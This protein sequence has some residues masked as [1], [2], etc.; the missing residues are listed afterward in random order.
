[1][2]ECYLICKQKCRTYWLTWSFQVK[3]FQTVH[4]KSAEKIKYF[5]R[6]VFVYGCQKANLSLIYG[7]FKNGLH[8]RFLIAHRLISDL[9]GTFLYN[10]KTLDIN[11]ECIENTPKG[12]H[13]SE[14]FHK[15]TLYL[16]H[17]LKAPFTYKRA[18]TLKTYYVENKRIHFISSNTNNNSSILKYRRPKTTLKHHTLLLCT[19]KYATCWRLTPAWAF[20]RINCEKT[21]T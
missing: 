16:N 10:L 1:M 11:L 15:P 18:T 2:S 5:P 7:R 12:G 17:R 14:S 3:T 13:F 21:Y 6:N 9:N 4:L 19:N 8:A 20:A